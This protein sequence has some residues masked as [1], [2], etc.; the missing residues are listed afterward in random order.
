M[1]HQWIKKFN[2]C[3]IP[4]Q[5]EDGG[6]AGK[7]SH[8]PSLVPHPS[9]L[10]P[11]PSS[12]VPCLMKYIG[13]L[14]RLTPKKDIES[15]KILILLSGPEPQRSLLEEKILN[16]I[17]T[18]DEQFLFVRG[19]PN[20][21]HLP[22]NIATIKFKNHLSSEE[23]STAISSAKLVICRSGYSSIMDLLKFR[24]KGILIP[25]PGQT[26]QLYLGERMKERNWFY[27]EQQ[28]NFQLK[29]AITNC[30]ENK[31]SAPFLNFKLHKQVL[32]ELVTQ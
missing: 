14:S 5:K 26:E 18:I 6:I 13:P 11:C 24:K 29:K 20:D 23:L 7:L 27:V 17:K 30:L 32:T 3:W 9:S 10:V 31:S 19:L 21:E 8:P 4:D 22:D 12:L 2:Q 25:T 16:Q 1:L 15:D 28:H